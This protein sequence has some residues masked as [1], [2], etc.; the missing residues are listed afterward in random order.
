MNNLLEL[1]V[2]CNVRKL[3]AVCSTEEEYLVYTEELEQHTQEQLHND[4][5]EH[6][7]L[8]LELH[9]YM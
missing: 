6:N 1:L 4:I 7:L 5:R 2:V 9:T 3:L 8:V